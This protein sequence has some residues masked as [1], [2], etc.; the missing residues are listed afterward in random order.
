MKSRYSTIS[1]KG[2]AMLTFLDLDA[3]KES[4]TLYKALYQAVKQLPDTEVYGISSQ[5]RRAAISISSNIAEGQGRGSRKDY[6]HF[7]YISRG[8]AY[9]LEAQLIACADLN[10][11]D[12]NTLT[13]LYKQ[14]IK[15]IRLLNG[16]INS[17]KKGIKISL[18][19]KS[20]PYGKSNEEM[21]MDDI[22]KWERLI[23]PN[24]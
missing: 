14:T 15:V 23:N 21:T 3:W 11:I 9:E 7:L 20:E 19:E 24:P 6:I 13:D 10:L 4:R 8:S 2:K 16:L 1:P 5:M 22:G 12:K 17:L 18:N